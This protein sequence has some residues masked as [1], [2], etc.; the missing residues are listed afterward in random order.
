MSGYPN[1]FRMQELPELKVLEALR[2][3]LKELE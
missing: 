2:V 3:C 1:F